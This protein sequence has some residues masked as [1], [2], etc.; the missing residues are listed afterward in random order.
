MTLSKGQENMTY[1]IKEIKEV[2]N[3]LNDFLQS[4]GCYVGEQVTIISHLGENL[5][6]NI[7]DSRYSIN[8]ELANSILI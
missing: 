3:D 2:D 6:L 4:L 5:I 8:H 1:S 7:K